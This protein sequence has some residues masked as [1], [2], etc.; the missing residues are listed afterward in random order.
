MTGKV[1]L[2]ALIGTVKDITDE[3]G[4]ELLRMSAAARQDLIVIR[5]LIRIKRN[6]AR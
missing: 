5:Y 3:L 6:T 1:F 4:T 2:S